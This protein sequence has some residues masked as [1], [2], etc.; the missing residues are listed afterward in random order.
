M[1]EKCGSN[2]EETRNINI[3]SIAGISKPNSLCLLPVTYV[4]FDFN[5]ASL[6]AIFYKQNVIVH[7]KMLFT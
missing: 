4:E 1:C 6:E 2:M 3:V 5:A 7:D